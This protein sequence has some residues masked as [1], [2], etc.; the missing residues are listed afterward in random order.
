MQS[1][2]EASNMTVHHVD[3]YHCLKC[4][5]VCSSEREDRVPICCGEQMVR[6]VANV[7]YIDKTVESKSPG[8]SKNANRGLA[9]FEE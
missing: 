7:T 3:I 5:K 6:A 2:E 8:R 1:R 4:G 9:S